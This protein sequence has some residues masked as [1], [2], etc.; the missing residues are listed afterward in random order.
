MKILYDDKDITVCIKDPDLLSEKSENGADILTKL[1]EHFGGEFT[2]FPLHRLDFG[3]GGTMVFAKNKK[4]AAK[5]SEMVANREMSKEYLAVVTGVPEESTG[6]YRDLLFKDSKKNKS[7]VVDRKRAGVKEASLEYE[8]TQSREINGEV[9]SLVKIKLHTGRSHQIR[10][11]FSSR[12]MPLYGD[13]KYGAKTGSDIALWSYR[14]T[15]NHPSSG[16]T[17]KFSKLPTGG[18]WDE[19]GFSA[20]M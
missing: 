6:I 7:F 8:V 12:K 18:I 10:V 17:V 2:F 16:E 19:F 14:L 1:E 5:M 3:V 15:F 9:F 20:I 11:Q 4:A 13:R